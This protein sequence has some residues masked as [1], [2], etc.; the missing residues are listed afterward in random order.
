MQIQSKITDKLQLTYSEQTPPPPTKIQILFKILYTLEQKYH[1]STSL[2]G[3]VIGH[4]YHISMECLTK[5]HA[6]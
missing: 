4:N 3:C 1:V 5:L 2:T 6:W